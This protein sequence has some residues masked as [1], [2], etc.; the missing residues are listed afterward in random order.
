M[1]IFGRDPLQV[2]ALLYAVISIVS[3]FAFHLSADQQG[4]L[5]AAL[6]AGFGLL[7]W[8]TTGADGHLAAVT[9]FA[10]A[11]LAVGLGFGLKMA[12]DQ[13]AEIMSFVAVAA[14]F[15]LRTQVASKTPATP[16]AVD[17]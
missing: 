4:V 3:M 12:P 7:G 13:Q 16:P 1:R 6:A 15:F 17:A 14:A 5:Q 9:G 10:K 11:V 8:A 2:L